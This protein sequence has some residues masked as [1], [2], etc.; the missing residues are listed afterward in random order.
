VNGLIQQATKDSVVD[1]GKK[2]EEY[3]V[4]KASTDK[5]TNMTKEDKFLT[6]TLLSITKARASG[7]PGE[8]LQAL[9]GS[10]PGASG[11][12]KKNAR[13]E[14]GGDLWL[15]AS[16]AAGTD[17]QDKGPGHESG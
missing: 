8:L 7:D 9:R 2:E 10:F 16:H 1:R 11:G 4:V 14:R 5:M 13:C 12:P 17:A 15:L 6:R 3:R